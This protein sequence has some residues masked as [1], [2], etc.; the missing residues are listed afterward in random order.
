MRNHVVYIDTMIRMT[1]QP[2]ETE[3]A[4]GNTMTAEQAENKMT[5]KIQS[6]SDEQLE[7]A[8]VA[9]NKDWNAYTPEER[10]VR[11]ALLNEYE[12]RNGGDAVDAM[13]DKLDELAA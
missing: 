4:K 6:L 2:S 1:Y 3:T 12:N 11:S 7:A 13:M 5:T 8:L 9:I 10:T